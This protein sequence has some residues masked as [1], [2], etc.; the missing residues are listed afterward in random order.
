MLNIVC[1]QRP[2]IS[3]QILEKNTP[4]HCCAL[5]ITVHMCS[6][7]ATLESTKIPKSD[8]RVRLVSEEPSS[9]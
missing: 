6:L 9:V 4:T 8:V 5:L 2:M 7:N 3:E 1:E